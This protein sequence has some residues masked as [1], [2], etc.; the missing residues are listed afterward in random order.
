[1][2]TDGVWN[3]ECIYWYTYT[4]RLCGLVVRIPG[5]ESR[6]PGF[7]F[8][9]YQIFWIVGLERGSLSLVSTI[10]ELLG[11]NSSGCGLENRE[12]GHGDPLRWPRD[13]LYPQ[14]LALTSLISGGRLVGI[15]RL[16]TKATEFVFLFCFDTLIPHDAELQVIYSATANLHDSEITTAPAKPFPACCIFTSCSLITASNSGVSSASR[17]HV[18]PSMTPVKNCLPAIS[19]LELD[20]LCL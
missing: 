12:Y 17:A 7:D 9:R 18:L 5:Y 2:T 13:T 8:R 1:V 10:E 15:V 19:S 14:K 11:R 4:D 6:G 16:R 20:S 3:G